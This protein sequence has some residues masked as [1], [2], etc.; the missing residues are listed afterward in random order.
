MKAWELLKHLQ[1]GKKLTHRTYDDGGWIKLTSDM[2]GNLGIVSER[3]A[4]FSL[5][6]FLSAEDD[7]DWEI[8]H[9]NDLN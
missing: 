4:G 1:E 7:D 3:G 6:D 5:L 9:E 8:Y 2:Y